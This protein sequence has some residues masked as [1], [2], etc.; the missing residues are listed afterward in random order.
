[1]GELRTLLFSTLYPSSCRPGHGVAVETRLRELLRSGQIRTRVVAPVPWFPWSG[2]RLGEWGRM[3][4]TPA[5][6]QHHGIDV[7]HPRYP[8][9]PKV[10]MYPA[11]VSLA[12]GAWRTVAQRMRDGVGFDL[13]DAH[14]LY[15][16]GVAAALLSAWSGRPLVVTAR[17]SDVNVIGRYP[18]ARRMMI[19]SASRAAAV[20]TVCRALAETL[21]GWGVDPQRVHVLRNGVD[22]DR[23]RPLDRAGSRAELGLGGEPLLLSV[24]N[25][26][27]VKGHDR[28]IEALRLLRKDHPAAQLVIVGRGPL[29]AALEAQARAA[30]LADAVHFPGAQPQEALARWYSAADLMLLSSR[31]EGWAN[32]LLEAMACGTPVVATDVGASADVLDGRPVGALVRE[33]TPMVITTAVSGLLRH[34]PDRAVVRRHAE[35]FSWDATTEAQLA[36]FRDVAQSAPADGTMVKATPQ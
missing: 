29:Q 32:V 22:L 10:G 35:G 17:G 15:P 18:L 5:V 8:L 30:G 27:E 4:A 11:P 26:V 20:I 25:L 6:E 3:A 23:F 33:P 21:I 24:G 13:I 28:S 14:Y 1:M 7:W 31:S 9:L 36:L 16:D 2:E 34:P 12:L 19:W